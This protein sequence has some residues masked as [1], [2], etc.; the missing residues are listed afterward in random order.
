MKRA[1]IRRMERRSWHLT[2]PQLSWLLGEAVRLGI[3]PADL[4]RRI[5]DKYRSEDVE[6]GLPQGGRVVGNG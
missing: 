6:S 3:S 4:L 1:E 5:I 2:E